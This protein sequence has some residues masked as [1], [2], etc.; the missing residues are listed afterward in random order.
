MCSLVI[1]GI[2]QDASC[3]NLSQVRNKVQALL[4]RLDDVQLFIKV[5]K[6]PLDVAT[7][8]NQHERDLMRKAALTDC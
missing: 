2:S 4:P 3:Q 1:G 7:W 5:G 6:L 8:L